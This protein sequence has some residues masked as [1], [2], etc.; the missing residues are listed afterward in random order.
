MKWGFN[1]KDTVYIGLIAVGLF[2]GYRLYKDLT[3]KVEAQTIAYKQLADNIARS[4]SEFVT[5]KDLNDFG[6]KVSKSFDL[7]KGDINKLG[8]KVV[9]VGQTVAQLEENIS[10]NQ[11]STSSETVQL[12][13]GTT[14]TTEFK[15]IDNLE[16][17]PMA[18]SKYTLGREKPWDIGTYPLEFHINTVLGLTEDD[19]VIPE[20]ELIVYNNSLAE[21]KDKP[22]K[23][24]I[25]SSDFK[26]IK[27]NTKQFFW[28][29]PHIDFGVNGGATLTGHAVMGLDVGFSVMAYGRTKNDNDWR[30]LRGSFGLRD[31]FKEPQFTISPV[32]YNLGQIIPIISDLWIYPTVGVGF[33]NG[34]SLGLTLGTTL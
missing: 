24:K 22:F 12:G 29:A 10:L 33:T 1:I 26:Q 17:L 34:Y 21:T 3:A 16:G 4:S 5:K 23:L 7:M 13:N 31:K 27:P 15:R 2:F 30:V 9:A 25:V 18:W 6:N 32:G 11:A 28:W 14:T 19:Q 8:G 20:N